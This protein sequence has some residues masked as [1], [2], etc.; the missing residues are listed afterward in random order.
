MSEHNQPGPSQPLADFVAMED[1]PPH[2]ASAVLPPVDLSD[3][4]FSSTP[5]NP[6]LDFPRS[7]DPSSWE[8]NGSF[9]ATFDQPGDYVRVLR[10][11]FGAL[12]DQWPAAN[13]L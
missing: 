4:S 12:N 1:S 7:L 13:M 8:H 11:Q 9:D 5:A 3:L 6:D 2:L 10:S